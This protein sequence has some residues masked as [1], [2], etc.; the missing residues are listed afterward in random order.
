LPYGESGDLPTFDICDCCGAE[1][2]YE[3]CQ[4]RAAKNYRQQWLSNGAK[5]FQPKDK[6]AD[7]DLEVQL[8]DVPSAYV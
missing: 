6:P 1:W 7:W 4:P 3:D 5:W 8:L 2:G